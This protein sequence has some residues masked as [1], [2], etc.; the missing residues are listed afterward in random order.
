MMNLFV[1]HLGNQYAALNNLLKA[2]HS[3]DICLEGNVVIRRGNVMSKMLCHILGFPAEGV[4][5]VLKVIGHHDADRM[6]WKRDFAGI[7]LVS[8]FI[9]EN[10]YLIERM[11][12]IQLCL[13]LFVNDGELHYQLIKAKFLGLPIPS[14]LSPK[15]T[16]WEK[17]QQG[18]YNFLVDVALPVMGRLISYEGML[19]LVT[20]QHK[21]F[22][23]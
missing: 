4:N 15:L 1:Q 17:E 21:N 10:D 16:A 13:K 7:K 23:S 22:D 14:A 12:P 11:G 9:R 20:S 3:G 6:L 19:S 18:R 2:A 8:E 5:V